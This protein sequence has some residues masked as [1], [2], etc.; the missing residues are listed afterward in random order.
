MT[1]KIGDLEE[2]GSRA[3]IL[4]T[5]GR[6]R[7]AIEVINVAI[8]RYPNDK[9]LYNNRCCSYIQTYDLQN[10]LSDAEYL[11]E[12]FPDFVKGYVRKGEVLTI[13]KRYAEAER[14]YKTALEMVE[15]ENI[16]LHL[17]QLQ[18]LQITS[19]G[20]E[21]YSAWK[22][23][24]ETG[25][26]QQSLRLLKTS[27]RKYENMVNAIFIRDAY[28]NKNDECGTV[29][30]FSEDDADDE[31]EDEILVND[32]VMNIFINDNCVIKYDEKKNLV[33]SNLVEKIPDNVLTTFGDNFLFHSAQ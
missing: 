6:H 14:E 15:D 24:C 4:A 30:S 22:A 23:L 19:R 26:V 28:L 9:R 20:F 27:Y 31:D 11:I 2:L 1:P 33:G 18:L 7:E 29:T 12:N 16:H 17:L 13:M 3:H 32:D 10:A 25:N 21:P 5:F 8:W